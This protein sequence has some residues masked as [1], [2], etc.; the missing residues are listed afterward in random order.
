LYLS[1][2]VPLNFSLTIKGGAVKQFLANL[3]LTAFVVYGFQDFGWIQIPALASQ[4]WEIKVL[5]YLALALIFNIVTTIIVA[6]TTGIGMGAALSDAPGCGCVIMGAGFILYGPI[7][8]ALATHFFPGVVVV[9]GGNFIGTV[10]VSW[11]L[12]FIPPAFYVWILGWPEE[13]KPLVEEVKRLT[14]M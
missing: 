11:G 1:V 10:L 3:C 2:F 4:S 9:A 14:G 13:L 12:T 7:F 8:F 6:L 5:G